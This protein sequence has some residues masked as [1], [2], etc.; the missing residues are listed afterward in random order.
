MSRALATIIVRPEFRTRASAVAKAVSTCCDEI[1]RYFARRAA[2]KNLSE[3][4]DRALRDIGIERSQ[5][6]SAVR[7]FIIDPDRGR[8]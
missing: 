6:E 7:H 3:L 2:I 5:I 4:D 1:A 8:M